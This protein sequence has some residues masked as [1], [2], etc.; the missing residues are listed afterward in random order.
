MY[1][2]NPF[3]LLKTKG[4]NQRESTSEKTIKKCQEFFR[5]L[6]LI[7]LKNSAIRLWMFPVFNNIFTANIL[8][9]QEK[10]RGFIP[11]PFMQRVFPTEG[12][13]GSPTTI[14]KFAH[15]THLEK[16]P[17]P[18]KFLSTPPTKQQLSSYN[19][20]KTAFLDAVIVPALFFLNFIHFRH[21]GHVNFDF[22][23]CSV[24]KESCF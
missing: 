21:T 14:W 12:D 20:I 22:N 5:I 10:R 1:H 3:H 4:V 9:M 8:G 15:P 13:G 6:I 11:P 16:S 24:F 23:W 2:F 19:P 17:P 18:T 7:W